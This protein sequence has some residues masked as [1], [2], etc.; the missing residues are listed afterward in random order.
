MSARKVRLGPVLLCLCVAVYRAGWLSQQLSGNPADFLFALL[1]DAPVLGLL[2][3]LA[4]AEGAFRGAWR[5]FPLLLTIPLVTLYLIDAVVVLSLN[6][7]LQLADFR[8]FTGEWWVLRSFVNPASAALVLA[9]GASFL[10]NPRLQAGAARWLP[11]G[12]LTLVL[13]PF[14][15]REEAIPSHLRKYTG[16]VLRLGRE[17]WGSR[18]AP[19]TRY[20]AADVAAYRRDYDA[21]FDAPA[22]TTGRD[23]I[24]VVVESLSA[25]DSF[26]TSGIGNALPRFDALSEEGM[27][28]RNFFA[29]FEA[30]EGGIVALASG[31]PPLHFPT[32]STNTFGEYAL[33]R[34]ITDTYRRSGYHCEF[35]TSVPLQFISM[36]QYARSPYVGFSVAAGQREIARYAGAPKYAFESPADHLLYEEL[37]ARLDARRATG[38]PALF[39]VVTAS[40][41]PPYVDPLGREDSAANVWAYVQDELWW[42]H[43]EL[44][45]RRFY[46]NGLLVITGDHRKMRPVGER[47]RQAYGDSAKARI[48]LL[49]IG[50]GVPRG[51]LD[52]RLFQQSDLLRM[53]DRAV[54][55]GVPLSP[56]ALWVERYVF[57]FGVASNASN[58]EVFETGNGATQGYRLKLHGAQIDWITPPSDP[59]AVERAVH[60]QRSVQQAARASRLT[61]APVAFGR[62]LRP[63]DRRGLLVGVSTDTDPSREPDDTRGALVLQTAG[64]LDL[65]DVEARAGGASQPFTLTAR[66]FLSVEEDGEYWF[67]LFADDEGC[68]AIDREIVLG[69]QPGLNEGAALLTP[70]AHRV[71]LRFVYRMGTKSLDLKWMPPGA[72]AFQPFPFQSLLAPREDE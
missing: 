72:A 38:Q 19:V 62:D 56:F 51:V 13:I 35:L 2:L 23:V 4:Y 70:G 25:V 42:L 21:L 69:C 22:A 65:E 40:S 6:A 60:R 46:E 1:A 5:L 20:R 7:R 54:R 50:A 61:Q 37:L 29:N 57:V 27:L 49:I 58:V 44:S 53:L 59:L 33:Q 34:S 30:S 36:D 14:A 66:G 52:D 15:V 11:A 16:T 26:R 24:L 41:H 68:L 63:S 39:A 12:A 18:S 43:D 17:I 31:V 10:V 64:A 55:P 45:R 28:F 47:E 32:A 3:A 48:P 67:S 71:D 8:R 9:A